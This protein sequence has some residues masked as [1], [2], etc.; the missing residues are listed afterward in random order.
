MKSLMCPFLGEEYSILTEGNSNL[1]HDSRRSMREMCKLIDPADPEYDMHAYKQGHDTVLEQ[2]FHMAFLLKAKNPVDKIYGLYGILTQYCNLKILEPDY[3]KSVEAVYT[4]V[5]WAWME[6]RHDLSILKLAARPDQ[7]EGLPSWVPAWYSEHPIFGRSSTNAIT[8][9]WEILLRNI[10]RNLTFI[11]S[12]F[13]WTYVTNNNLT[14]YTYEAIQEMGPIASLSSGGQLRIFGARRVGKIVQAIG[15]DKSG[16]YRTQ[17]K[18][19]LST[20]VRWCGLVDCVFSNITASYEYALMEMF[21]T[22]AIPGLFGF[23]KD[24]ETLKE[25]FRKFRA[26][27]GYM[28]HLHQAFTAPVSHSTLDME[29]VQS[30]DDRNYVNAYLGLLSVRSMDEAIDLLRKQLVK[31]SLTP[32][33]LKWMVRSI[34]ETRKRLASVRNYSFCLLKD[35][36]MMALADYWCREGDEI[37]VFSDTDC[38]F[39]LRRDPNTEFYRLIGPAIV[40]R[41]R[42]VGYQK[43]RTGS[44]DLQDVVLV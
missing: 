2:L 27:F 6:S 41:I 22:L 38:P 42:K 32:H 11:N 17:S 24:E 16:D 10:E 30:D 8:E 14:K 19:Y 7:F 35:S 44:A 29:R 12:N 3:S 40:D 39:V 28:L 25:L 26:W 31:T 23:S 36:N 15:V 18:P 9:S 34:F 43:W 20:H 13:S 21:R 37:F 5:T 1:N 33:G 4:E